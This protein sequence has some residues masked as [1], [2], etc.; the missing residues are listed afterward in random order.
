MDYSLNLGPALFLFLSRPGHDPAPTLLRPRPLDQSHLLCLPQLALQSL[1]QL[2]VLATAALL[3]FLQQPLGLPL[4]LL[5]Q[6]QLL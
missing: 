1:L 5:Q 6:L 4:S 3:L 2:P